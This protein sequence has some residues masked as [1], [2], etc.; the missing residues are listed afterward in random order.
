LH[1]LRRR[2]HPRRPGGWRR[3][4]H[5]GRRRRRLRV[6]FGDDSACGLASL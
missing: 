2:R 3:V 6:Q 5:A 4:L 1:L